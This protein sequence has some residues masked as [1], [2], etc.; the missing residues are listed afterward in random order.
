MPTKNWNVCI[1]SCSTAIVFSA[2]YKYA[3]SSGKVSSA[4]CRAKRFNC[5]GGVL[6]TAVI[7]Q[8]ICAGSTK[9]GLP[10]FK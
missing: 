7:S 2:V 4:K 6:Q 1:V 3:V 9:S 8:T 10:P 5:A